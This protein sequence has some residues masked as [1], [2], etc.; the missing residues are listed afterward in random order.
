MQK[1]RHPAVDAIL[2]G[3]ICRYR[4]SVNS[5]IAFTIL[6]ALDERARAEVFGDLV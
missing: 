2:D 3:R 6:V 1:Y 4:L 5:E